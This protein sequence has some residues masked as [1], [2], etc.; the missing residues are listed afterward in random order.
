MFTSAEESNAVL[1]TFS[2]QDELY[3]E[4][5]IGLWKKIK[6]EHFFPKILRPPANKAMLT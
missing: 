1:R 3:T 5:E 6:C 2:S 4:I